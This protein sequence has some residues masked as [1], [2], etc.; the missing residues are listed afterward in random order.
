[1]LRGGVLFS[2]FAVASTEGDPACH[3]QDGSC[4]PLGLT[5]LAVP[6]VR[7]FGV[8]ELK[9]HDGADPAKPLLLAC[10]G[11]V[12]DVS[13]GSRFY[14]KG[15]GYSGLAG[16]DGSR[17]FF[18][19][20]FESQGTASE[21]LDL[22][23]EGITEVLGWRTFYRDHKEYTFEGVLAERY[24]DENGDPTEEHKRLE[25]MHEA[26]NSR[27]KTKEDLRKRFPSCN[28]KHEAVSSYFEIWCD[29][30]YH[31]RGSRPVHF[32]YTIPANGLRKAEEGS[33]CA[34][35]TKKKRKSAEQEAAE[36]L[37]K[38]THGVPTFRLADY[39]ECNRQQRCQ[40]RKGAVS[41]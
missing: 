35:L 12:Y 24:F 18:T 39:P 32:Y 22:D 41:P 34:C 31:G 10:L 2:W 20:N 33:W 9:T 13:A 1:M 6:N 19:G 21:V 17:A 37:E 28:T 16:R 25:A 30:G 15:S 40:R 27:G 4:T 11:E 5:S 7:V 8:E 29:N 23:D 14:A 36:Q 38:P 26:S 3:V